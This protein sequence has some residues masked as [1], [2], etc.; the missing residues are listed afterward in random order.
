MDAAALLGF[1]AVTVALI[2]LPGP[3]WAF[4]L[5]AGSHGRAVL[6]AVVGLTAGYVL[7]TVLVAVGLG[8]FVA[9]APAVLVLLTVVGGAYLIHLGVGAFRANGGHAHGGRTDRSAAAG[10]MRRGFGVSALNPKSL[11]FFVVFLPQ[12]TRTSASWPVTVQLAVLGGVW[13][14]LSAAF[15]AALGLG[16]QRLLLGRPRVSLVVARVAGAAMVLAGVLLLADQAT[17]LGH[18]AA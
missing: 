7:V 3:D 10:L 11:L 9:A 5:S 4:L 2:V 1:V 8:Q 14:F 6:S 16:A 13:A 12:F 18:W 17:H 15:Y